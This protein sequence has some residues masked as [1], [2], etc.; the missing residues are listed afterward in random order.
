MLRATNLALSFLFSLFLGIRSG[1]AKMPGTALIKSVTASS[2]MSPTANYS[3]GIEFLTDDSLESS[4]VEGAEGD[5]IGESL[6]FSLDGMATL[7]NFTISN[8]FGVKK[9]WA[10]NNRVKEL[11]ISTA[12]GEVKVTLKDQAAPQIV[13]L[14]KELSGDT[15]TFTIS[16]VYSGS[17]FKDTAI[18]DLR[19]EGWYKPVSDTDYHTCDLLLYRRLVSYTDGH[20]RLYQSNSASGKYVEIPQYMDFSARIV[21]SDGNFFKLQDIESSGAK[22]PKNS[23]TPAGPIMPKTLGKAIVFY[24]EPREGAAVKHKAT[25]EIPKRSYVTINACKGKWV[26]VNQYRGGITGWIQP[27]AHCATVPIDAACADD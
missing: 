18:A 14:P 17:K 2:T 23:W 8:G 26:H 5:G 21:A 10:Q 25:L 12:S 4:W 27:S 16:A 7:T 6:V 20:L 1:D 13:K 24:A 9:H 22:F 19:V 11:T 15:F 3:Y